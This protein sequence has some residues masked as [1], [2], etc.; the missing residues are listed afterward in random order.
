[1]TTKI[2]SK[3]IGYHVV[4]PT[5]PPLPEPVPLHPDR[6]HEQLARPETLRGVTTKISSPALDH[7]LYVTIND[8]VLNEGTEHEQRHPFEIFVNSKSMDAFQWVVALT[9][10]ISAVFRKGGDVAFLVEELKAV[11]D[12]RGGY[13]RPG[14]VFM[15]SIVAEIGVVIESHLKDI[16]II[17]APA[18][19][20]GVR[21]LVASKREQ[22]EST[23]SETTDYPATATVCHK[24][25]T[26]ALVLMDNC[27][28]CLSCGFSKCG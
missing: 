11:F 4:T 12:P 26:K 7:A 27:Q 22:L 21:Q 19:D 15:P 23:V 2:D 5:T 8:L 13:F 9:R 25:Q 3:I 20:E 28:T 18:M 24:C 1:M 16:G 10:L 6:M 17:Q 14:G